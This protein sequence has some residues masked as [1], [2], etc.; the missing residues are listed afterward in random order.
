MD[1][2]G[3]ATNVGLFSE[4]ALQ[5]LEEKQVADGLSIEF[6]KEKEKK[7]RRRDKMAVEDLRKKSLLQWLKTNVNTGVEMIALSRWYIS[8]Y[9][10]PESAEQRP[11]KQSLLPTQ[12]N[13]LFFFYGHNRFRNRSREETKKAQANCIKQSS[14]LLFFSTRERNHPYWYPGKEPRN[15]LEYTMEY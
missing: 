7:R 1:L 11:A 14:N 8:F 13:Y 5:F 4:T 15:P 12:K 10:P 3:C 2:S 9:D 6:C